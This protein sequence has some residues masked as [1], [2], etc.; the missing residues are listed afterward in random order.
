MVSSVS[1]EIA[2]GIF[3][4][5]VWDGYRVFCVM[6]G[7]STTHRLKMDA[8]PRLKIMKKCG[9]NK[10]D[11]FVFLRYNCSKIQLEKS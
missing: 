1:F 6:C 7:V 4:G 9:K 11:F 2:M 3:T 8:F 10:L 5:V